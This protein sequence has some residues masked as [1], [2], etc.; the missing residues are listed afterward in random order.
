MWLP[1]TPASVATRPSPAADLGSRVSHPP[2]CPSPCNSQNSLAA[3]GE[4]HVEGADNT[5]PAQQGLSDI[6]PPETGQ[7]GQFNVNFSQTTTKL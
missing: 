7:G 5:A 2:P 1:P 6:G 3:I 4:G